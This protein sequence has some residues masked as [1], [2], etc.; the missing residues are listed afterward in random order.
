M[1][2]EK[3]NEI[4]ILMNNWR[5]VPVV[6][7][8]I[9]MDSFPYILPPWEHWNKVVDKLKDKKDERN[10]IDNTDVKNNKETINKSENIEKNKDIEDS[11]SINK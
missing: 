2:N 10:E 7:T 11:R 4:E 9:L 5:K 3:S 6:S 8:Q 1:N